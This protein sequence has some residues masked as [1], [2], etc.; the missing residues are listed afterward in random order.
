MSKAGFNIRIYG[1][2]LVSGIMA[3]V[4]GSI[5]PYIIE[6]KGINYSIAGSLLSAFAIGNFAAS[7]I[8][9]FVSRLIGRKW[10]VFLMTSMIPFSFLIMTML[11]PIPVMYILMV[12]IG[13]GRGSCSIFSNG[14]IND[15]NPEKPAA[16]TLLH[17]VF[18]VGAFMAP[19]LTSFLIW[20][21]FGWKSV[22]YMIIFLWVI[23]DFGY[24]TMDK[25]SVHL[26]ES[27]KN[28]KIDYYFLRNP[29]FYIMG[30]LLFFYLGVENCVNGWFITYF[31]NTG[32]MSGT[33]AAN[34]VSITWI[35]VM[36]GRLVT[37]RLSYFWKRKT[38]LL[39]NC[40]GCAF[41]FLI[42]IFSSN[43]IMITLA[44]SGLGFFMAGIYP[45]CISNMGESLQ[46][47]TAGMAY[48]LAMAALGGII[49]PKLVGVVADWFGIGVGIGLLGVNIVVMVL[50]A[51]ANYRRKN[52]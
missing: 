31:K 49:A 2:F 37:A 4:V 35:M 18:A 3:L 24:F 40:G 33:Y 1:A 13:I 23:A 21:G 42:L 39:M 46:G 36:A 48:L 17:T 29:D 15:N 28:K 44:I 19:F 47:S 50:L 22:V 26:T 27:I 10:C 12:L 11:P 6:E 52:K 38:L 30:F 43:L 5:L 45:T 9:P 34:L 41:F 7:F 8:N 14:V 16:I 32:M 25:Q 51:I 20:L